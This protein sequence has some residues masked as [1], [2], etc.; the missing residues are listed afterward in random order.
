MKARSRRV[1]GGSLCVVLAVLLAVPD[2][3]ATPNFPDAL[4]S[5]WDLPA[6]PVS[7]PCLLRHSNAAGGTG[8]AVT[9]FGSFLRSRGLRAYDLASLRNALEADRGEKHDADSNGLSDDDDLRAGEDPNGACFGRRRCATLGHARAPRTRRA[10]RAAPRRRSGLAL[11][12]FAWLVWR[13]RKSP[14]A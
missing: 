10:A 14:S 13:R 8:T 3:G 9:P 4:R 11:V 2:A 7:P 12:A 6:L 1:V 5:T